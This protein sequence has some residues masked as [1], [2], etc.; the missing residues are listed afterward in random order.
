MSF[1]ICSKVCNPES[2]SKHATKSPGSSAN[3][4]CLSITF[5][6]FGGLKRIDSRQSFKPAFGNSCFFFL[7]F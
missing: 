5:L 1:N 2:V 7:N 3:H 4:V 6:C